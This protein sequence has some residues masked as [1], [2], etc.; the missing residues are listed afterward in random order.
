[1]ILPPGAAAPSGA[2]RGP[3]ARRAVDDVRIGLTSLDNVPMPGGQQW[4]SFP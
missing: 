2:V 1:V 3:L 4:R